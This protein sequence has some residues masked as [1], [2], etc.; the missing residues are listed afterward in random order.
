[1][2][3][4][5]ERQRPV[6][7]W[8]AI[9][10]IALVVLIGAAWATLAVVFPPDRV[11]A[12]VGR[13]LSS[14]LKRDVRFESAAVKLWPPVRVSVRAPALAEVGG[15]ERGT[16]LSLPELVLAPGVFALLAR[17]WV[18]R[19]VVLDRPTLHL[20]LHPN[21]TTNLG[22][23]EPGPAAAAPGELPLEIALSDFELRGGQVLVDDLKAPRRIA[24]GL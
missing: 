20:V 22:A 17:R 11:R 4:P 1:M 15:F 5:S 10:V 13:E 6:W 12:R 18:L 2:S 7:R 9:A 3:D 8:L 23:V 24:F 21:G 14:A 16:G 19:R